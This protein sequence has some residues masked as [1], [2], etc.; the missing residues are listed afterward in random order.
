MIWWKKNLIMYEIWEAIWW[1]LWLR[2]LE[3]SDLF[4]NEFES[5]AASQ[6][7]LDQVLDFLS[8]LWSGCNPEPKSIFLL[9]ILLLR[10][11]WYLKI[12]YPLHMLQGDTTSVDA[13]R[14][15]IAFYFQKFN[16]VSGRMNYFARISIKRS[17]VKENFTQSILVTVN[18][19]MMF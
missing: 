13:E 18:T 14:W 4:W 3:Y 8:I 6:K 17:S 11:K 10:S 1:Y 5:C 12:I 7:M 2:I 9:Q 15:G 16:W 19:V